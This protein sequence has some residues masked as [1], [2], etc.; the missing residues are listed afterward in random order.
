MK[1]GGPTMSVTVKRI[2]LWRGTIEH[3]PGILAG[4]LKPLVDA[5]ADL[6]VAM[7]YRQPND[8]S[9][10]T[11][12]VYPI[13][14]RSQAAAARSVGLQPG[15]LP[16]LLVEGDDRPGMGFSIAHALAHKA[17]NVVFLV[18]QVQEAKFSA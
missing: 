2:T 16:A 7:L 6:S 9:Q 12:E 13:V 10:A 8:S 15:G 18:S 17:I 14:G 11:I 5:G 1:K 4:S 3:L